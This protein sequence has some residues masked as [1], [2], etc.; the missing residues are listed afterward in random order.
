MLRYYEQIQD[1]KARGNYFLAAALNY[2]LYC[3]TTTCVQVLTR[4]RK[5]NLVSIE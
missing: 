1:T 2:I 4:V 5:F 3:G